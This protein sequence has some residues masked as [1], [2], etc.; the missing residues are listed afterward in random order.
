MCVFPEDV[1]L[2]VVG[3][4]GLRTGDGPLRTL[5]SLCEEDVSRGGRWECG[6]APDG[7]VR[8]GVYAGLDFHFAV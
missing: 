8:K 4:L 2:R 6:R 5:R 3:V 1:K 7:G